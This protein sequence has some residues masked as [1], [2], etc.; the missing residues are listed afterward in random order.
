MTTQTKA[1]PSNQ[2][3]QTCIATPQP[4]TVQELEDLVAKIDEEPRVIAV[5]Y[6]ELQRE[7][8]ALLAQ[9]TETVEA[10]GGMLVR[11]AQS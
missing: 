8:D 10:R 1:A 11:R 7:R 2:A 3:S 9:L 5:A 4:I 6:L